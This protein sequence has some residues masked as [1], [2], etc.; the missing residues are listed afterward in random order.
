MLH[1]VTIFKGQFYFHNGVS[2]MQGSNLLELRL[3]VFW[4][5]PHMAYIRGLLIMFSVYRL[6]PGFLFSNYESIPTLHSSP[7]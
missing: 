2:F 4:P 3:P 6:V 1:D 5:G 7:D